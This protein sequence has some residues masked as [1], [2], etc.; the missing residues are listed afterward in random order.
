MANAIAVLSSS[1][2][3]TGLHDEDLTRKSLETM[4]RDI[5]SRE[6]QQACELILVLSGHGDQTGEETWFCTYDARPDGIDLAGSDLADLVMLA[7]PAKVSAVL[8]FCHAGGVAQDFQASLSKQIGH[9]NV[10]ILAG[11]STRQLAY[12]HPAL[13]RGLFTIALHEALVDK[14][15]FALAGLR[16]ST[17]ATPF[18]VSLSSD[19]SRLFVFARERTEQLAYLFA[20]GR[21]QTPELHGAGHL[22][23][24]WSD[25]TIG[26]PS[27]PEPRRA[28]AGRIRRVFGWGVTIAATIG[29]LL[30]FL[31]Y[32][33]AV[34]PNGWIELRP[35]PAW[36]SSL[37]PVAVGSG[38]QLAVAVDDLEPASPRW[39]EE[40][41]NARTALMRGGI[42]GLV[43]HPVGDQENWEFRLT[44]EL[45]KEAARRMDFVSSRIDMTSICEATN[46]R[47]DRIREYQF[48]LEAALLDR[49]RSCPPTYFLLNGPEIVDLYA[50]EDV[51]TIAD[52][53]LS[54]LSD[55]A[56]RTYLAGLALAY[57]E[58]GDE[59]TR[60]RSLEAAVL[61]ISVRAERGAVKSADWLALLRFVE[62][63]ARSPKLAVAPNTAVFPR[64]AKCGMSWCELS[65]KIVEYFAAGPEASGMGSAAGLMMWLM[66]KDSER[67]AAEGDATRSW[68]LPPLLLLARR[69]ELDERD[70]DLIIRRFGL[71]VL[72]DEMF[73][74]D[75][76]WLPRFARVVPLSKEWT[77]ALWNCALDTTGKDPRCLPL[78]SGLAARVLAAQGRF[79]STAAL[80]RL[81]SRL[82]DSIKDERDIAA[83]AS[84]MI[85]LACWAP[86]PDR[87]VSGLE[88]GVAYDVQI[89][90]PRAADP[91]TGVQ[92]I[93]VTDVSVAQALSA[94]LKSD[95]GSTSATID[96]LKRYA[97]NHFSYA[98]LDIVYRALAHKLRQMD[99]PTGLD[100]ARSLQDSKSDTQARAVLLRALSI[101][102][103]LDGLKDARIVE[104]PGF[105]RLDAV[106][107]ARKQLGDYQF[108]LDH[109]CE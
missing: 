22:E 66:A 105:W 83:Y 97:S 108:E 73:Y 49:A 44:S 7:R 90:P 94:S 100:L 78:D 52:Y 38:V 96:L 2:P 3:P 23:L 109:F 81:V 63:I 19:L 65:M 98:G 60:R 43:N 95:H 77:T 85:D 64:L 26:P 88:R 1:D 37:L 89:A 12:E 86:M 9:E 5:G 93:E 84:E 36:M 59:D 41:I 25:A 16:K 58:L 91:L 74:P 87:W 56:I 11:A 68:S 82:D 76:I 57:R 99:D 50:V 34:Q 46:I 17:I 29:L 101:A 79:L 72:N 8:D 62:E 102:T 71:F 40:R 18:D 15:L 70:L 104:G 30:Y 103:K 4:F 10:L 54:G 20:G 51:Q 106:L 39:D 75:A 92:I 67:Q 45:S 80:A 24:S 42:G 6:G 31:Q 107:A 14:R 47:R 61:L 55:Q 35:G 32:H 21:M 48:A 28:L 69:G 27:A 33:I 13:G 53:G